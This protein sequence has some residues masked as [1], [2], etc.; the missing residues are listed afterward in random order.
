MF[1]QRMSRLESGERL[2]A[3]EIRELLAAPD[4][5]PLGMLA[6]ALR[7][8]LRGM[9]VTFVR[10]ATYPFDG[11][12]ADAVEPAAREVLVT[13]SPDRL[14][15]AAEA[16]RHAAAVA[17]ARTVVAFSWEDVERLAAS[18][19]ARPAGPAVVEALRTLRDAGLD[20]VAELPLDTMRDPE[21]VVEHLQA[22]GY[23]QLRLTVAAGDVPDR[24]ALWERASELQDRFA[25]IQTLSPLPARSGLL[26]PTTGYQDVKTVAAARLAAPNIPS[27]QVDWSRYG[28]KL[29]QVALTFGADDLYGISGDDGSPD[30]R[31]RAPI[32]EIR[33]NIEAAGLEPVERDGRFTLIG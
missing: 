20:R 32:E 26:R 13:G 14:D 22:A 28:P 11:S 30:G 15:V 25:C 10:V 16:I 6:D 7:R 19:G 29:A 27:I 9:V 23:Q 2:T 1:D 3:A 33:R 31:R 12:W 24:V 17:G 4:I 21:A 18:I 8:R 5:L